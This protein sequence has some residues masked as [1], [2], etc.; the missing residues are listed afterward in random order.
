MSAL[1]VGGVAGCGQLLGGVDGYVQLQSIAGRYSDG[2]RQT[3]ESI[4][5]VT[6]SSPPGTGPPQVD[7]LHDDWASQ[8]ESPQTPVVS[9]DLHDELQRAYET[10][11]YVVGVC[12]PA[13]ADSE[14]ESIGCYNVATTRENFNRVQVHDHVT[15]S[16]DGTSLTIHSTDGEWTFE[17]Q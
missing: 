11:R 12:S 6:L 16:S 9:D 10:V 3:E 15:V 4:L 14:D 5:R 8:F 1:T 13:W 17:S 7:F 2:G